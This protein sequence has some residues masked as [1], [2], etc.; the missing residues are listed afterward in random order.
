[1]KKVKQKIMKKS[2]FWHQKKYIIN[3]VLFKNAKIVLTYTPEVSTCKV[4][5][6]P[7]QMTRPNCLKNEI[8]DDFMVKT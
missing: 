3:I 8:K 6:Y 2:V 1:M 5:S 4:T 7:E